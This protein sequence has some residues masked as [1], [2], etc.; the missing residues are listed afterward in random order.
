MDRIP[1]RLCGVW[2]KAVRGDEV[3]SPVD[4][5]EVSSPP[6]PCRRPSSRA[7]LAAPSMRR[8]PTR[9][10]R[11]EG[12]PFGPLCTRCRSDAAGAGSR[13]VVR[14]ASGLPVALW[15]S[16][17]GVHRTRRLDHSSD[18]RFSS[19]TLVG[20]PRA[21][22]SARSSLSADERALDLSLPLGVRGL[23]RRALRR[24]RRSRLSVDLV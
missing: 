24:W 7:P 10:A 21:S 9:P 17:A 3:R 16:N 20:A 6:R 18:L 19:A 15:W 4:L 12:G 5:E 22:S 23:P 13:S 8:R 14:S 11:S 2:I 1:H